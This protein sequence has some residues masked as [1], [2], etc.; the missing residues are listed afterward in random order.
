MSLL[1]TVA[2]KSRRN[3]SGATART[4]SANGQGMKG[5]VHASLLLSAASFYK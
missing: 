1:L 4:D 5:G 3:L 2:V